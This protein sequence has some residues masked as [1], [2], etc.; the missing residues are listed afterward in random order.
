MDSRILQVP[1]AE[2]AQR[3]LAATIV[4]GAYLTSARGHGTNP[5]AREGVASRLAVDAATLMMVGTMAGDG[6]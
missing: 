1:A 4:A 2:A 3:E 6:R 5:L